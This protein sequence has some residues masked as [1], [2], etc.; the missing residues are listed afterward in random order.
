MLTGEPDP[1]PW[2][3]RTGSLFATPVGPQPVPLTTP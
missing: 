3:A 1:T 2:A